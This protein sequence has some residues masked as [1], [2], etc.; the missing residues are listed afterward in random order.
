MHQLNT[1]KKKKSIASFHAKKKKQPLVMSQVDTST[2]FDDSPAPNRCWGVEAQLQQQLL[3]CRAGCWSR[4][5]RLK[6]SWLSGSW[7]LRLLCLLFHFSQSSAEQLNTGPST[8][9]HYTHFENLPAL[10]LPLHVVPCFI[11]LY[12]LVLFFALVLCIAVL[13]LTIKPPW[14]LTLSDHL[15]F[16]RFPNEW[17]QSTEFQGD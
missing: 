17:K 11:L 8:P 3:R 13:T 7:T 12:F 4:T 16:S 14:T 15:C 2:R 10:P 6:D 5:S 1:I 9:T